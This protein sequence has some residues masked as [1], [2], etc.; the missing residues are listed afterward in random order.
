MRADGICIICD[1]EDIEFVERYSAAGGHPV[2]G[3]CAAQIY[4]AFEYVHGDGGW[5]RPGER[6]KEKP[7]VNETLRWAVF[8]RDGYKCKHCGKESHLRADH[9]IPYSADG[10]TTMENLQ[11]LCHSCNSKKGTRL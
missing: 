9:V 8:K 10:E 6:R 5:V 1:A 11:T 7:P 4:H 3:R 2:C